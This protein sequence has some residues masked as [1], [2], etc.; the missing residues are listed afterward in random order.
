MRN[1]LSAACAFLLCAAAQADVVLMSKGETDS[2]VAVNRTVN[3]GFAGGANGW[4]G[5]KLGFTPEDGGGRDGSPGVRCAATSTEEQH[6]AGQLVMLNQERPRPVAAGGWSRAE[7]VDGTADNGYS[8]YVDVNYADGTH[9][10][11]QTAAFSTGTHDWE[12]RCVQ[13]VPDRPVASLTVHALFR[14]HNGTVWFDDFSLEEYPDD[15]GLF[16]GVPVRKA[17]APETSENTLGISLSGGLSLAVDA[18]TGALSSLA[19]EGRV[20]GSGGLPVFVRDAAGDG[21]FVA[22]DWSVSPAGDGISLTGES[23]AL[24]LRLEVTLRPRG[25]RLEVDGTVTDLK[26]AER[27][28][29]VYVPFPV[30][31]DWTWWEDMRRS[32]PAAGVRQ[33][34]FRTGAGATGMRA[35][36]PL[37]VLTGPRDGLMLAVPVDEPRHHRL[38]Y[39]ADRDL[40]FAAFDFGLSPATRIFPGAASFRLL[41]CAADPALGFRG[42]LERYYR[43]FPAAF[44]KRIPTEGLWM[45][46]TDIATLPGP[47]DFGFAFQEGAPNIVWDEA[48]GILSFPYTEPMTTWLKLDPGAPRTHD[49]AVGH[50]N[51]LLADP[52]HPLHGG[53]SA[54]AVSSVLD[55]SGKNVLSVVNAP[56]CDGCVFALNPDPGLPTTESRPLNRGQDELARLEKAVTEPVDGAVA[57]GAYIDSY[58]F[59]A[60]SIDYSA[61]HFVSAEIPLVFDAQSHRVGALTV[62]SVF[63][64]QKELARRMHGMGK[65]M[66]ANGAL[67]SYDLAAPFL[68]VLGTETNWMPGG[69][70]QPMTDAELCFRRALSAR[71]PYCFLMNTHYA[72]FTLELTERY[73]Q[74]ALAYGMFPGFFSENASTDCYFTKPEWYEPARPLFKKYIPLIRTIAR[75]GWQPVTRAASGDPAVLLERFGEPGDGTVY[76]TALNDSPEPRT[77]HI[78][79]DLAALGWDTPPRVTEMLS[80]ADTAPGD[81]ATIPLALAPEQA[82]LLRFTR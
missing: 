42:A 71:K 6:G 34:S 53:A 56:W 22:P 33:N 37:A 14:G 48:H 65:H 46:F 23:A 79:V 3:P 39:D 57:D 19:L 49:G 66:M 7:G 44:E 50:L 68:D 21:E 54:I 47:E 41:L 32:V 55:A 60:N 25:D 29:T 64:F 9:L 63:T 62:F 30:A 38:V 72:D 78:T 43:M 70:W 15:L 59:W 75:A 20:L 77:A 16:E 74:R 69:R 58:E 52:A 76:L 5:W 4:T 18:E 40:L 10:W 31:G 36:Y 26:G 35:S 80:G 8:V 12:R 61:D 73:M 1:I 24:R 45:A 82:V 2:T 11:G 28:V 81:N 17:P 27:A 67:A 13:V 51:A